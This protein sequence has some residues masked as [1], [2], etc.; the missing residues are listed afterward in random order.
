VEGSLVAFGGTFDASV[1]VFGGSFQGVNNGVTILGNLS[2]LNPAVYSYNGFW[3]NQFGTT[4]SVNGSISYTIDS[5]TAYPMYQSPLLYFGGGTN[6][7]GNFT[8]SDQG[9]GFQGHLDT[10]GLVVNGHQTIS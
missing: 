10:G 6:V 9:T 7:H 3:G 1:S 2:F 5:T 4:N 8:Y